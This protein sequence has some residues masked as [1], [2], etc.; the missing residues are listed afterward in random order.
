MNDHFTNIL[1]TELATKLG[2]N[3]LSFDEEGN[4]FLLVDNSLPVILRRQEE[5]LV[6]I[7]Q[8]DM[9]LPDSAE[10]DTLRYLLNTALNPLNNRLPGIG[11]HQELGVVAYKILPLLHLTANKLE[12]ELSEFITWANK[13]P[14]SLSQKSTLQLSDDRRMIY[15][16]I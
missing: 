9:V 4:C 6:I 3:G 8:I 11:W 10:A 16:R 5:H 7:C 1:M 14:S 15:D 2:M 13:F 12:H